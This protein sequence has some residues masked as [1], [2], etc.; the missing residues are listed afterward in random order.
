MERTVSVRVGVLSRFR[1]NMVVRTSVLVAQR[2]TS[3]AWKSS[4][5]G[6]VRPRTSYHLSTGICHIFTPSARPAHNASGLHHS[7][8]DDATWPSGYAAAGP[9][10][11]VRL[12]HAAGLW[13]AEPHTRR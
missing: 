12:A 8:Y 2:S 11:C 9:Q 6:M 10:Y 3:S 7:T 1:A 13:P 4:V 5:G